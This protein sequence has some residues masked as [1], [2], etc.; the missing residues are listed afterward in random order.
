MSEIQADEWWMG[1]IPIALTE[2][3]QVAIDAG[4]ARLRHAEYASVVEAA[5]SDYYEQLDYAYST[6]CEHCEVSGWQTKAIP[7]SNQATVS[8]TVVDEFLVLVDVVDDDEESYS[9]SIFLDVGEE[10]A[11]LALLV[12]RD[13]IRRGTS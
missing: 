11:L 6:A 1:N 3:E 13:R 9:Q 7:L 12:E 10:E 5:V 4:T 8:W 2:V